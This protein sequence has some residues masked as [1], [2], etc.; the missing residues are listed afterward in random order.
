MGDVVAARRA[1]SRMIDDRAPRG[2]RAFVV[3]FLSVLV[4]CALAPWNLWPFSN[5]ELFSRVRTD[6]QEGW[7]A[8]AVDRAG[9]ERRYAIAA[10]PHG[11]R[12]FQFIMRDFPTRSARERDAICEVWL[13][14]ATE[15]FGSSTH[16]VAIYR[17]SWLLSDR[18]GKRAAP[19]G[20]ALDWVCT[21]KGARAAG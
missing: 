2:A 21:A 12:G 4:A 8:V 20:R 17:L 16:E 14:A 9:H 15:R 10:L 19:P 18:R 6:R 5:W 11:F 3:V 1:R 13:R 7:E